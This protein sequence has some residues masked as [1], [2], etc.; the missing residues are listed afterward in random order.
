MPILFSEYYK[1]PQKVLDAS[2]VFDAILDVDSRYFIDPKLLKKC[3]IPEFKESYAKVEKCFNDL[4]LLLQTSTKEGDV[5]WNNAKK[6]IDF[7]EVQGL[8][9]G[10][11][12]E[13]TGGS[14]MGSALQA[15]LLKTAKCII[16]AGT[17]NPRIFEL[18]GVFEGNIGPDRIS[19]M[20]GRI[21]FDDIV[22][23]TKNIFSKF[24]LPENVEIDPKSKLPINPEN[25]FPILLVPKSILSDL[26]VAYDW[27]SKDVLLLH[28]EQLRIELNEE[29][30]K[31]W[32]EA[33]GAGVT[34]EKLKKL[35]INNPE[36]MQDLI[37]HY[38]A[39]NPKFYDFEHDPQGDWIWAYKSKLAVNKC[40]LKLMLAENPTVEEVETLVLAICNKFKQLIEENGLNKLLYNTADGCLKPKNESAAQLLFY[41]IAHAYCE[42]NNLAISPESDA[43]R[44]PVDFKFDKGFNNSVLVEVKKSTNTSNLLSGLEKQLPQYMESESSKRA[45]YIVI[46]VGGKEETIKSALKRIDDLS[47]KLNIQY[48]YVDALPR[49]SASKLK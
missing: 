26:P 5:F 9:I 43:G 8:C 11:A 13:G 49:K 7:R 42:A 19:D 12:S 15:R 45:V 20:L 38:D 30:G 28:N 17:V 1:V 35:L 25:N 3:T 36:L 4:L 10:Y 39:K 18:V 22:A 14:G 2:N 24:K 34:K 27:S 21:I 16:D 23:Y 33:T 6:L 48:V 37:G 47:T 46:N 40:P 41:G 31:N 32:K 29:I 44:G